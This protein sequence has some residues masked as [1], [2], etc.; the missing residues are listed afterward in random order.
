MMTSASVAEKLCLACGLCC[1]GALF[2]DVE[3]QPDDDAARLVALGLP[4]ERR[5]T[6]A[7]FPQPCAALCADQR[8]RVYSERPRHCRDFECALFQSVAAGRTRLTAALRLV[9]TA[10]QRAERVRRGLRVLGDADEPT[11]L[12]VRFRRTAKRLETGAT[13]AASADTFS[14]ITLAF[15]RLNVLLSEKFYPGGRPE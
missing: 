11:A 5:K 14:R 6:Q 13:D 7:R 3:L 2:R 1:D 8:C 12:S 10:R 4:V 9:A 15:H